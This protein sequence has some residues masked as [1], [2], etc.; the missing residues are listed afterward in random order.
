MRSIILVALPAALLAAGS[1]D[2]QATGGRPTLERRAAATREDTAR[3]VHLLERATWGV[4]R[5]DL[6]GCFVGP[7]R[8]GWSGSFTRTH[9]RR[10]HAAAPRPLPRR[11]AT[12]ARLMRDY[13]R[14]PACPAIP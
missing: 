14:R 1:A 5:D 6:A 12:P 2:A 3:A 8:R 9:R 10:S 4:R 13:P 11:H 7:G